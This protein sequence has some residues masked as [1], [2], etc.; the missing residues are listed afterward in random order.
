MRLEIIRI[1][2]NFLRSVLALSPGDL[3]AAVYLCL[4]QLGP[5]YEVRKLLSAHLS[6]YKR[7]L[8]VNEPCLGI[9]PV[10]LT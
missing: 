1:L 2:A 7:A 3:P 8:M 9:I 6:S 10:I 4:N 5:T